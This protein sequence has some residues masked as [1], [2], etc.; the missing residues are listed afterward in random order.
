MGKTLTPINPHNN[1]YYV[2][3]PNSGQTTHESH[4][5]LWLSHLTSQVYHA[6]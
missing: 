1:Y 3:L 6:Y 4:Y 2:G 5:N